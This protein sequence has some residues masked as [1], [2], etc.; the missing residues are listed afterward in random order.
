MNIFL[1]NKKLK[2]KIRELQNFNKIYSFKW[3]E[4]QTIGDQKYK[5]NRYA[6]YGVAVEAINN[7]CNGEAEWGVIFTGSVIDTRAILISGAGL[8]FKVNSKNKKA[9]EWL[10]EYKKCNNLAGSYPIECTQS[11][12]KEAKMLITIFYDKDYEWQTQENMKGMV[13]VRLIPWLNNKYEIV[14]DSADY[15]KHIKVKFPS[16]S[17]DDLE[18][19]DFV[20]GKIGGPIN[21]P[22]TVAMKIWKVLSKIEDLDMTLVDLRIVNYLFGGPVADIEV[23]TQ[24]DANDIARH[25]KTNFKRRKFFIH[26]GKFEY[27]SPPM[28]GTETMLREAAV[29][30]KVIS[31]TTGIPVHYLG[32]VDEMS[33]RA[34][35][36]TLAEALQASTS[37]ERL[38]VQNVWSSALSKSIKMY[39]EEAKKTHLNPSELEVEILQISAEQWIQIEKIWMPAREKNLISLK[40]YLSKVPGIDVEEELKLMAA[41][42]DELIKKNKELLRDT[43][44]FSDKDKKD[45]EKED[46]SKEE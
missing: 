1:G 20:Y 37:Y 31:G 21:D 30:A 19:K 33:N 24:K 26:K 38:V 34:T 32:F 13:K 16:N 2:S 42:A 45:E 29:L 41:E 4:A 35:A 17:M 11:V 5:S 36:D 15:R 7:K 23:E 10:Q 9:I 25:M 46:D 12:E 14:S 43:D 3:I 28:S 44:M 6:D 8:E 27:K 40:T 39:N 22:N 18:E